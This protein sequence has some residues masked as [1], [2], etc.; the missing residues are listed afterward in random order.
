MSLL[1]TAFLERSRVP[2][3]A[4]LEQAVRTLGFDLGIDEYYQPFNCSGFL[5]CI[6]DGKKSG[7]EIYFGAAEEEFQQFPHLKRQVASRDCAITFRWGGDMRECACVMIVSAALA[8]TFDAIV[9]Y[10]DDDL[11]Y[12]SGQLVEQAKES[13]KC[14]DEEEATSSRDADSPSPPQPGKPWWKF[15]G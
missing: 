14:A 5:P 11:V 15:W 12:T 1:Q 9:H 3:Q 4:T 6:L 13:V 7:F 10:Q 2:D 8:T